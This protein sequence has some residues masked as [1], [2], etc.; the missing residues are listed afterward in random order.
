MRVFF[1]QIVKSNWTKP[2]TI[3]QL[4]NRYWLLKALSLTGRGL[5]EGGKICFFTLKNAKRNYFT[6]P[7]RKKELRA[8]FL[9]T[10]TYYIRVP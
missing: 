8:A 1:V 10:K 9:A 6:P 5:G 7:H 2:V 4:S 3:P